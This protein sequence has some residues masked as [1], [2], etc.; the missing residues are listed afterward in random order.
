MVKKIRADAGTLRVPFGSR[1]PGTDILIIP[2]RQ[3]VRQHSKNVLADVSPTCL[4]A[5]PGVA[6]DYRG[7]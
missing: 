4:T 7:Q 6:W 2:A 5:L 1:I 3:M